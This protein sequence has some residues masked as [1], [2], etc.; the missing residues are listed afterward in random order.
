MTDPAV[1]RDKCQES[2]IRSVPVIP[3][4]QAVFM[5]NT[6]TKRFDVKRHLQLLTGKPRTWVIKPRGLKLE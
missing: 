6:P 4:M 1:M 2:H 3:R 5:M